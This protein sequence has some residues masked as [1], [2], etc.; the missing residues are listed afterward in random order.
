VVITATRRDAIAI[1]TIDRPEALNALDL[2]SQREFRDQL[3]A[4]RDDPSIAV[5]VITGGGD[6]S[7]CAGADLKRT[8]PTADAFAAAWTAPDII[9]VEKGAYVRFLNIEQL[10]IAKPLIAAIN[11][12]CIGGGLEI[13]LQCDLR[14]A[15]VTATFA[16]PEVKVGSLAGVCGPLLL[17]LVPA[18]H[19]MKMLLAGD[20]IDAAEALRIGLVSDVWPPEDLLERALNLASRI[21]ANAP[22]SVAATK[23]LAKETEAL[24]RA[25]LFNLTEMAFGLLKDT[26]D[27]IEGR[28]AFAEKRPPRFVGR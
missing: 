3:I 1:I 2:E 9:A 26:E 10:G 7:F 25:G 28:R 15:S 8:T 5:I 22:L 18:A 4:A 17:R 20:R 27:R 6:R 16:L 14:L 21:A 19:A 13:A 12:H 23:R 11:G 24:P